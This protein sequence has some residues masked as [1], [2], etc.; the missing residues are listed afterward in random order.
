MDD[1]RDVCDDGEAVVRDVRDDWEAVVRDVHD[2]AAVV[3]VH[4]V[5]NDAVVVRNGRNDEAAA[6]VVVVVVHSVR[7]NRVVEAAVVVVVHDVRNDAEVVH[8]HCAIAICQNVFGD[9][10]HC[11]EPM[12]VV[13]REIRCK[14]EEEVVV[15]DGTVVDVGCTILRL[16]NHHIQMNST[17]NTNRIRLRDDFGQRGLEDAVAGKLNPRLNLC[18]LP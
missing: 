6:A 2:D 10:H 18:L 7:N 8:D 16:L 15:D 5:Q 1:V 12:A 13:V 3:V 4:N 9:D 17:L 11:Q 14:E